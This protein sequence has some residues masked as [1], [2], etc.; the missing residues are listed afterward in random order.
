MWPVGGLRHGQPSPVGPESKHMP[1]FQFNCKTDGVFE[2]LRNSLPKNQRHKCPKC[3]KSSAFV[4]PL[5]V[6]KP[7]TLWAGHVIANQGYFTSESQLGR[8][9]KKKKHTRIGDRSDIEGMKAMAD[10][11]AKARDAKFAEES[12]EFMRNAAGERGLLDAFGNLKPEASKP[13]TDTPLV[14]SNDPRVKVKP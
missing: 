10:A 3:G 13:L 14:S 9:M 11:A 7:D 8:V 2:V 5:T 4:W 12:S 1:L 6:M